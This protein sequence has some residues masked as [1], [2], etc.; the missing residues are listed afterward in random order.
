MVHQEGYFIECVVS[1]PITYKL[2]LIIR[3]NIRQIEVRSTKY[4][5]SIL[6]RYQGHK[7]QRLR[8]CHRLD[9]EKTWQPSV[10]W[11]P[12]LNPRTEKKYEGLTGEI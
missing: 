7:R 12:R 4:P 1:F 3:K 5:A 6:Q 2:N 10:M 9:T 11:N 8:K